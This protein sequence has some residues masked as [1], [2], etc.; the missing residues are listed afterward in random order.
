MCDCDI[1]TYILC[2]VTYKN[3]FLQTE[4]LFILYTYIYI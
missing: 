4:L 1:V 3:V 2:F